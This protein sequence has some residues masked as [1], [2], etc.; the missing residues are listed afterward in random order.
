MATLFRTYIQ[1]TWFDGNAYTKG[2]VVDIL[3]TYQVGCVE[4]PFETAPGTQKIPEREWPGEDGKDVFIPASGIP[5]GDYDIEVEFCYK[6]TMGRISEDMSGFM[7]FIRGR[8]VGAVGGRLAVYDEHVGF[9]RKDVVAVDVDGQMY[10]ADPSDPDA[11]FDF[12]VKFHVYDPSSSVTPIRN[13]DGVV[14]GFSFD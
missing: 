8:N 14:T 13:H 5:L 6:G 3:E 10:K 11:V 7:D 4:F 1:Q 9:G 2:P 12:K